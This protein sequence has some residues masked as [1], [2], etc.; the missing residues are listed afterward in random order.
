[1]TNLPRTLTWKSI[2][3]SPVMMLD[4]KN[5]GIAVGISLLSRIQGKPHVISYA[6][7]LQAAIFD[8]SLLILPRQKQYAWAHLPVSENR[9]KKFQS[10]PEI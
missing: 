6:F 3:I 5:I 8:F 1:M 9:I 10:V 2:R 4:A 7:R